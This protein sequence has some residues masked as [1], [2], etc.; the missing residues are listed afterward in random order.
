M[1]G[2][3]TGLPIDDG[4]IE[5]KLRA[6]AGPAGP[7]NYEALVRSVNLVTKVGPNVFRAKA[8]LSVLAPHGGSENL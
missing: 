2:M 6:S 3:P 8:Y 5:R 4:A 7:G 1:P